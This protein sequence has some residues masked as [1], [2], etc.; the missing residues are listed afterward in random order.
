MQVVIDTK[1]N[2]KV[3]QKARD[4]LVPCAIFFSAE[5]VITYPTIVCFPV[6]RCLFTINLDWLGSETSVSTVK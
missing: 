5:L 6:T 1:M 4:V 2:G 3:F